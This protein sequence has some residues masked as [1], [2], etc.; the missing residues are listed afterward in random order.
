MPG[1]VVTKEADRAAGEA[2][3]FRLGDEAEALH[4]SLQ[5][6]QGIATRRDFLQAPVFLD[7]DSAVLAPDC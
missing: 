2:R 6:V 3:Q 4:D 7:R 1:H 5:L